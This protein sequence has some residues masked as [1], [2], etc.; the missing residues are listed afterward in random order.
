MK[1]ILNCQTVKLGCIEQKLTIIQGAGDIGMKKM[2]IEKNNEF[3]GIPTKGMLYLDTEMCKFL[4]IRLSDAEME[5]VFGQEKIVFLK[6]D[7][8]SPNW[9]AGGTNQ[10]YEIVENEE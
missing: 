9:S 3:Y 5:Y 4:C 1:I 8:A 7:V 10:I 2:K 6:S